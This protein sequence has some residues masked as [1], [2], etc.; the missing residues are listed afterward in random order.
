MSTEQK[1]NL[2]LLPIRTEEYTQGI[3][4]VKNNRIIFELKQLK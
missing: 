2:P 3:F 4:I 1:S